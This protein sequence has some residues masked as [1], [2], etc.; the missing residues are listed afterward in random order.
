MKKKW[1]SLLYTFLVTLLCVRAVYAQTNSI[2]ME[3]FYFFSDNFR[4]KI[5]LT[6]VPS[7]TVNPAE[8]LQNTQG[9]A[10][11]PESESYGYGGSVV[12]FGE[13][14]NITFEVNAP[15]SGGYTITIDYFVPDIYFFNLVLDISVNGEYQFLEEHSLDMPVRWADESQNYG[16]DEFGNDMLPVPTRI[17][18]WESRTLNSTMYNLRTPFVF[19]LRKGSNIITIAN[20][21]VAF[22]LGRMTLNTEETLPSAQEYRN[23]H[24]LASSGS[25]LPLIVEGENYSAKSQSFIVPV[26]SSNHNATPYVP[27]FQRVNALGESTWMEPGN[28]VEYTFTVP[29]DGLYYTVFRYR[30]TVAKNRPA[31]KNIEIDGQP[32]FYE[33]MNYPFAFTGSGYAHE[34]VSADGEPVP[35]F[36]TKG[37]HVLRIESTADML[38]E[39]HENLIRI[40]NALNDMTINITFV[41]GNRRDRF[42][43]WNIEEYV[44]NIRED[45]LA[46]AD[47]LD[48]EYRNLSVIFGEG[49]TNEIA[50]LQVSGRMLLEFAG[51]LDML[52]N[53]L[54]RLSQG[55]MS[56][57][58]LI[59]VI[60]PNLLNQAMEIEKIYITGDLSC[61]P[62]P[63]R[64]W[65]SAMLEHFRQ[66]LL[67]FVL[68]QDQ[69]GT[70]RDDRLNIW[71]GK[72]MM[73]VELMRERFREFTALTGIPVNI[74]AMPDEQRLLLAVSAGAGPDLV[75]GASNFRPF[76]FALRGAIYN[77]RQFPDFPDIL[78]DFHPEMFVPFI[79][80]DG[81]YAV[82]ETLDFIVTY[83][84]RDILERLGLEAPETWEDVI[85][86]LPDLARFG[87]QFNS[88]ISNAG[89]LKHFGVTV[90]FILQFEGQIYSKDGSHVE[91][92]DPNTV[93]AF[94][95]MTDLYTRYSLPENIPSFYN[96]FRRGTVPIGMANLQNYYLIRFGAPELQGQWG[97]VPSV[98]V[99]GADGEVRNY[100]SA[101]A[102]SNMIM[103]SSKR[104]DEAW[105]ALKWWMKADTQLNYA[106]DLQLR[107]GSQFIHM[108]ANITAFSGMRTMPEDDKQVILRQLESTREIP[109]N[110]AY[111]QVERS[112]SNA[113]NA[114]VFQGVSPRTALDNAI[115]ESNR[116][117]ANK[118]TEFEFMD[119]QGNLIK[120]FVGG[121]QELVESWMVQ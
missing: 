110:P 50:N 97:M 2:E 69:S 57:T 67:T 24:S 25:D 115:I 41:T 60:L 13:N 79:F 3:P 10:I 107:F 120:P 12:A 71:V 7:V 49:N 5:L 28:F 15:A 98:G 44:P 55:T 101:V 68:R 96:S 65:F 43:E 88:P 76:D 58:E 1:V 51:N 53:N 102:S 90:P 8:A 47:D 92:G 48:N 109:R 32:L 119:E 94:R 45:L 40:I 93:A 100:Q 38:F 105:E 106:N 42:R 121:T 52:V 112:L 103:A 22:L 19:Y 34:P 21:N 85:A 36:L 62:P 35:L 59:S 95:F 16:Q 29:E 73:Q 33:M 116:E 9:A 72:N 75:I 64:G 89:A 18:S 83:Y 118:L 78:S 20:N 14:G 6:G 111:F 113:W 86:M 66:F 56:V 81:V 17:F 30:I 84:R 27:G 4:E 39:T 87:M 63:N 117:I 37:S 26:R 11:A 108:T 54:D 91:L 99:L 77:L 74:S 31:F 114:T 70:S 104:V 61:L 23:I 46:F 80:N 82:P